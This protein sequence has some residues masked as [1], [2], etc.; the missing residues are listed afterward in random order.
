[1]LG[2]FLEVS[3]HCPEVRESME[4]YRRLGLDLAVTNDIWAHQYA[5][6]TDGKVALGLHA[7]DF[8]S[9]SLTWVHP[10]L[11]QYLPALADT[12]VEFEFLKTGEDEFHEA[13]FR[14]PDGQMVT[15]LEARTF[16]PPVTPAAAPVIGYFREYRCAV[17]DPGRSAAFWEPLGFV[18]LPSEDHGPLVL[19]S[20]G[21][22]LCVYEGRPTAPVLVYAS[23][24]L[25]A[26]TA[27]LVA[28][29]IVGRPVDDPM[30]GDQAIQL[31]A[32]E[33]SR[34]LIVQ[35]TI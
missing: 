22:D 14:D 9:P 12:G 18:A 11:A 13:G 26:A 35:E 27:E 17:R 2:Q 16:S 32:P 33:G 21:I 5:A 31:T 28:R 34:L 29:G 23:L 3:I 7:Y 10:G 4:F 30:G 20:D 25:Q 24:D 19:T 15:V 6:L 1:M 8:P